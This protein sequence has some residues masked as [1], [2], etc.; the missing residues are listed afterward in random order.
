MIAVLQAA[1]DARLAG[2]RVMMP[3]IVQTYDHAR[4]RASVQP[5]VPDGYLDEE[6]ERQVELLPVVTEVPVVFSG[7]TYPLEPG[8]EV[9]LVFASS[10]IEP[11]LSRGGTPDPGDDRRHTLTDAI[12]YP[13]LRHAPLPASAV[14]DGHVIAANSLQLGSSSAADGV[15]LGDAFLDQHTTLITAIASAVSGIPTGG[16]AA[17]AAITAALATFQAAVLTYLSSKVAVE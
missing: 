3:G 15:L 10:S 14:G 9:A 6:G 13:G 1:L 4:Q 16:A 11:W 2:V 8:D 5:A 17:G 12:A 7:I